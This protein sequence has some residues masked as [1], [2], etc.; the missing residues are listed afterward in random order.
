MGW[1]R[2]QPTNPK[3]R[4]KEH[5]DLLASYKQSIRRDGYVVCAAVKCLLPD[6]A[7]TNPHG[8]AHDGVTVGHE[9]DGVGI[10]GPEHRACNLHDAAVR[11]R[12]RQD[13]GPRRWAL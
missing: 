2:S 3:Y 10:R 8:M 5:R 4:S 12:A 7:I 9:D 11:A 13:A 6:R 1:D